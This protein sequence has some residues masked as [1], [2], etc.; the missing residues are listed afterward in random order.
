M[1]DRIRTS[2]FPNVCILDEFQR[3]VDGAIK[4]P[5]R[6]R[7]LLRRELSRTS[8]LTSSHPSLSERLR[9]IGAAWTG[10]VDLR[11]GAAEEY[12]GRGYK[13]LREELDRRWVLAMLPLWRE[14]H[15]GYRAI[16]E[17]LHRCSNMQDA[18][19][20]LHGYEMMNV[21][22]WTEELYGRGQGLSA[23]AAYHER[24]PQVYEG[25]F[26]YGRLLLANDDERGLPL[27]ESLVASDPAYREA[28]LLVMSDFHHRR[29]NPGKAQGCE[30][31]LEVFYRDM[32]SVLEDRFEHKKGDVFHAHGMPVD[33]QESL[34]RLCG[35]FPEIQRL[36]LLRKEVRYFTDSPFFV[37]VVSFNHRAGL[38]EEREKLMN[39][40]R[41]VVALPGDCVVV[42]GPRHPALRRRLKTQEF[43]P[44]KIYDHDD[45]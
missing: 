8:D 24:Y 42:D 30:E 7:E 37:M 22:A 2:N 38:R 1:E 23:Y 33:F 16:E 40:I 34:Y 32:K 29:G 35:E 15:E 11:G 19:E 20:K 31:Q 13:H 25:R 4:T 26:H 5:Q 18:G 28:G 6:M 27:L 43:A 14:R 45:G 36:H 12:F 41:N 3:H 44:S 9:N 39:V 21:A 17:R 10:D